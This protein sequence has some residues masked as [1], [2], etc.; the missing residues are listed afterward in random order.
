MLPAF[1]AVIPAFNEEQ[2]I[3]ETLR[4]TLEYLTKQTPHSEL[5]VVNDG[6]TDQ[7]SS[8]AREAI[9]KSAVQTRLLENF[10]N[11]G[12]GHAVRK[13]LLAVTKPIAL[14]FDADLATPL[15][16]IPKIIEPIA[17]E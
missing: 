10:P 17:T 15:D 8:I 13:G 4:L 3:G 1:S 12:K 6:S 2:R 11:R 9:A 16:E 14:F 7:T 5:I